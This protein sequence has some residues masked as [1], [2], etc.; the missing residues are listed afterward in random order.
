MPGME[1]IPTLYEL[2]VRK[3]LEYLPPT[4]QETTIAHG[5]PPLLDA[6]N[7][8]DEDTTQFDGRT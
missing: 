6:R 4:T 2:L 1:D 8:I 5:C 7:P 3:A